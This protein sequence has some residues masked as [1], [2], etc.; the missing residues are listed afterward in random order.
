MHCDQVPGIHPVLDKDGVK[1]EDTKLVKLQ[2]VQHATSR[3]I[4]NIRPSALGDS[5]R[6]FPLEHG[7][8][9]AT[10]RF[11]VSSINLLKAHMAGAPLDIVHILCCR[12]LKKKDDVLPQAVVHIVMSEV[13]IADYAYALGDSTSETISFRYSSILWRSRPVPRGSSA[14][15]KNDWVQA[16]WDGCAN[17]GKSECPA[18]SA[19]LGN[20]KPDGAVDNPDTI[21]QTAGFKTKKSMF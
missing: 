4:A 11:D 5:H 19:I 6:T 10:R 12:M 17:S 15:L 14:E 3:P 7:C 21:L 13:L 18:I 1:H 9:I 8:L 2:S 16:H 20:V